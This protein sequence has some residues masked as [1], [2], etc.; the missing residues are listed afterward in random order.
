M[1]HLDRIQRIQAAG[2]QSRLDDAEQASRKLLGALEGCEALPDVKKQHEDEMAKR[3]N[4]HDSALDR[5]QQNVNSATAAIAASEGVKETVS[6]LADWA[7]VFG[8]TVRES[9]DIPLKEKPL[10]ELKQDEQL[11]RTELDSRLALIEELK[12]KLNQLEP[13]IRDA[14]AAQLR[15]AEQRLLKGATHLRGF[16]DNVADALSGVQSLAVAGDKLSRD[17]DVTASLVRSTPARDDGRITDALK[18]LESVNKQMDDIRNTVKHLEAIPNATETEEIDQLADSLSNRIAAMEKELG[19]KRDRRASLEQLEAQFDDTKDRTSSWLGRFEDDLKKL[20][21]VSIER[22]R[23]QEQRKELANF[24]DRHQQGHSQLEELEAVGAKLMEAENAAGGGSRSGTAPR[25]ISELISKYNNLGDALKSRGD[26][27]NRNEQKAIE[28]DDAASELTD[29]IAAHRKALA[30]LPI[31]ITKDDATSQLAQLERMDKSGR[32]EQRRLDE[33]RIRARELANEAGVPEEAQAAHDR[34]RKLADEWEALGD[35]F[36]AA[37]SRALAA[38]KLLE[39]AAQLEK[40]LNG[41]KRMVDAIGLPSTEPAVGRTQLGQVQIMKAEADSE[42]PTLEKLTDT[43][44]Q[45]AQSSS[46]K[47]SVAALQ[48][49]MSDLNRRWKSLEENL[50]EKEDGIARATALGNEIRALQKDMRQQIGELESGVDRA[51]SLPSGQ[52][53]KQLAT[54]DELKSNVAGLDTTLAQLDAK[55]SE[56][57]EIPIDVTNRNDIADQIS[58]AKKKA[59][60]VAKKID[61]VKLAALSMR[62]EGAALEEQLDGLLQIARQCQSEIDQAPPISADINKLADQS[63]ASAGIYNKLISKEGD[64]SLIRAKVADQLKRTP[65]PEM[66]SKSEELAK[67]WP[68]LLL[69]AKD[70]QTVLDKVADLVRQFDDSANA[71]EKRLKAD[72]KEL[73]DVISHADSDPAEACDALKLVESTMDRRLNETEALSNLA[74]RIEASAPGPDS[75]KL[76]RRADNLNDDAKNIVKRAKAAVGVVQRKLDLND[77]FEKLVEGAQQFVDEQNDSMQSLTGSAANRERV[78]SMLADVD[79][80]WNRRHRELRGCGDELKKVLKPEEASR[81]PEAIENL[82]HQFDS[83]ISALKDLENQLGEKKDAVERA[84]ERTKRLIGDIQSLNQEIGDLD[85]IGRSQAELAKQLEEC[86]DIDGRLGDKEAELDSVLND[87]EKSFKDGLVSEPQLASNKA[88]CDDAKRLIARA[89]KRLGQ[90]EKGIRQTQQEVEALG[91]DAENLISQLNAISDADE[92]KNGHHLVDPKKQADGIKQLKEQ[93]KPLS[94]KVDDFVSD[95]KALIKTAGP[96]SDTTELDKALHDVSHAWSS[97]SAALA[98]RELAVDAAV[99]QLGRYEDAH[100]ALLNWLEETEEMVENQ[101]PPAADAKVAKA[102][103][104]AYEVL[105]K[106]IEDKQASVNGFANLIDKMSESAPSEEKK[107]LKQKDEQ[108][109]QRHKDLLNNAHEK[110]ARLLEAVDLAER[111]SEITGPLDSWLSQAEKKLAPLAKVPTTVDKAKSQ[112]SAQHQ[113]ANELDSQQA[114]VDDVIAL[115]PML[116]TLVSVDDAAVVEQQSRNLAGRHEALRANLATMQ[117]AMSSLADQIGEFTANKDDME[118]WLTDTERKILELDELPIAPD[119]LIEQSNIVADLAVAVAEK[120]QLMTD[121]IEMGRELCRQSEGDEAMQLQQQIDSMKIRYADI[122]SLTD[123]K[124]ALLTKAIPLSERFHDG[125][126]DV[127]RWTEAVEQDLANLD[128]ADL[129]AQAHFLYNMED[130][131]GKWRPEVDDLTAVSTQL[132]ALCSPERAEELYQNT[133]EMNKIVNQIADKVGRRVERMDLADKQSRAILD[134]LDFLVDWLQDA[135]DRLIAAGPPS[136]DPEFLKTQLKNQ[137]LMN[138]DV[139]A[140]RMKL[141]DVIAEARKLARQLETAHGEDGAAVPIS[142]LVER[143]DLGKQLIDEVRLCMN[144][145]SMSIF[146]SRFGTCAL[147]GLNNW[148]EPMFWRSNWRTNS[149]N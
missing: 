84:K 35:D 135:R 141:R 89:R 134:D 100:R 106:H 44:N 25:I 132:Q 76:K 108:I 56:A 94:S 126:E 42:K 144:F 95:C 14:T 121:I 70:R 69:A 131:I 29:R 2:E 146:N 48:Q 137:K 3:R 128:E 30:Q 111:L 66:K 41:K 107:N 57:D 17:I 65:D 83:L 123:E 129:E 54:L 130:D 145:K 110:Q 119:D 133:A 87:W 136:I 10:L 55:L 79:G 31:P 34:E 11:L 101:K 59:G 33:L 27:I 8:N 138:D 116:C 80:F 1:T 13:K 22:P 98:D 85:H 122:M 75:N 49:K 64:V 88:E 23:L 46:D 90:R 148:S 20:A 60:E 71:L 96:E 105:L 149:T 63:R 125:F 7:E 118:A 104:N 77:K 24:A 143:C 113:L 117:E 45:L 81:I 61:N 26:K 109:Q 62:T 103:H 53:D 36:D 82:E 91:K 139:A 58:G 73:D 114:A 52:V 140:N 92:M 47:D 142:P 97:V 99:Q 40:W 15:E 51:A 115:T 50:N 37:R 112:E 16:R 38:E 21:P 28:V 43:A 5:L 4:R 72:E 19:S 67:I 68:P 102:Q 12:G 32:G 18:A 147:I 39:G 120:D 6:S 124:L 127:M 78:H 93:L 9:K 86:Q 74:G